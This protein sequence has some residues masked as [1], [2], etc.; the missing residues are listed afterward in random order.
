M[1]V[2][3]GTDRSRH[4]PRVS[5]GHVTLGRPMLIAGGIAV[6]DISQLLPRHPTRRYRARARPATVLIVHHS[7]ADSGLDGYQAFAAMAN[8]HVGSKDWPG[9]AYHWG[10]PLRP[11]YDGQGNL[12][13]YQLNSPETICY[14]TARVNIM[15]EGLVLQGH[16][17]RGPL[18]EYQ[19]ECLEAFIPW[20]L[21]VLELDYHTDLGWHSIADRWGG[22]H[23]AA[24]PGEY[25][26]SWL[27]SYITDAPAPEA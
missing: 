17:G 26:E 5:L 9:I 3:P 2:D 18:S 27:Q 4:W 21:G 15:G 23:K 16:H 24:C 20:R 10:I 7:G 19:I 1:G 22:R 8:Y 13:I 11:S 6:R 12:L 14:H 25:A